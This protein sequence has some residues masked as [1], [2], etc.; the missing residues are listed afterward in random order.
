MLSMKGSILGIP[1]P[2]R[3]LYV[4]LVPCRYSNLMTFNSSRLLK[5]IVVVSKG[6]EVCGLLFLHCSIV[7]KMQV[8]RLLRVVLAVFLEVAYSCRIR[9]H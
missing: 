4:S 8:T 7:G 9:K 1:V 2:S 6:G 5:S 3:V